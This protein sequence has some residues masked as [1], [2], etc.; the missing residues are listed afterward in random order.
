MLYRYAQYAGLDT[1]VKEGLDKYPDSSDVSSW[2]IDAMQW[3]VGTGIISG[4]D[5]GMYLDPQGKTSR[6]ESATMVMRF[7][8]K[9]V[10]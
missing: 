5:G 3:A 1:S 9:Y 8:E 4:K 6:A 2:A 7:M 10:G